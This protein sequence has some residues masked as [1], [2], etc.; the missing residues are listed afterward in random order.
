MNLIKINELDSITTV[1]STNVLPI[2]DSENET[3]KVSITQLK[4]KITEDLTN[5]HFL[6]VQ[7]LPTTD[8]QTNVIYLVPKNPSGTND[9]YNE[10][11]YINNTWEMLGTTQ[12][13]LSGYVTTTSL[14]NILQDYVTAT[15]LTNTLSNY[16]TTSYV[17]TAINN[18]IGTALG[19]S[20]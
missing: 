1:D 11:A 18:A 12:I 14:N 19:G 17:T 6:I 20:Y 8:I 3:K 15:N 9:I 2:V 13:D 10:Y 16:A 7:T 4:I 5:L